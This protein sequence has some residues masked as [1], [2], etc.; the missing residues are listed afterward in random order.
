M[1][2]YTI[3]LYMLNCDTKRGT[4]GRRLERYMDNRWRTQ[5]DG[6]L[7]VVDPSDGQCLYPVGTDDLD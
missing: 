1:V 4:Y 6:N 2:D 3:A 5:S 7:I